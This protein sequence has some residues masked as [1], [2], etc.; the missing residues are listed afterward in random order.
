M[1][2]TV[3]VI[4]N[5]GQNSKTFAINFLQT[6][7]YSCNLQYFDPTIADPGSFTLIDPTGVTRYRFQATESKNTDSGSLFADTIGNWTAIVE[8]G[9]GTVTFCPAS[10]T[11]TQYQSAQEIGVGKATTS[12]AKYV[13]S[14]KKIFQCPSNINLGIEGYPLL[15]W[16][17]MWGK[18]KWA[19]PNAEINAGITSKL[20]FAP[21]Y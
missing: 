5:S 18:G 4:S 12:N 8:F 13:I 9:S 7:T 14:L 2:I 10:K 15:V 19:K 17:N 20:N 6:I 3:N 16:G 11:V 1:Q 21:P